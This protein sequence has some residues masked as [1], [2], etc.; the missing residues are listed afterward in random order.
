MFLVFHDVDFCRGLNRAVVGIVQVFVFVVIFTGGHEK[1]EHL[2]VFHPYVTGH[3]GCVFAT[4]NSALLLVDFE[5]V[6]SFGPERFS[7]W[8][9]LTI[10]IG[11][12]HFHTSIIHLPLLCLY[13]FCHMAFAILCHFVRHEADACLSPEVVGIVR[14]WV[15]V[16]RLADGQ[17]EPELA[18]PL[19]PHVPAHLS[20]ASAVQNSTL[21]LGEVAARVL[22]PELCFASTIVTGADD[23]AHFVLALEVVAHFHTFAGRHLLKSRFSNDECAVPD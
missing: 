17:D 15:F 13:A 4:Q 18:Q 10:F 14:V 5:V 23:V 2:L 9:A 20:I 1:A 8:V 11:V 6:P 16:M 19:H 7:V 21:L 22:G 12:A 3:L